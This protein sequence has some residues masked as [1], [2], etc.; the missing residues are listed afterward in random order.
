MTVFSNFWRS[1]LYFCQKNTVC[2]KSPPC[3]NLPQLTVAVALTLLFACQY[4]WQTLYHIWKN[5]NKEI[6]SKPSLQP[7]F[8][9]LYQCLYLRVGHK[10]TSSFIVAF[11]R[12]LQHL[13][14]S[15]PAP[16]PQ[17]GLSKIVWATSIK[18]CLH[19]PFF[20]QQQ[21]WRF[22][23]EFFFPNTCKVVV[24]AIL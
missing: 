20:S 1:I 12:Y 18:I 19:P 6:S 8:N 11:G 10:F 3:P 15:P 13:P 5:I 17:C 16:L 23:H 14:P 24:V 7:N 21:I 2:L 4:G 22:C 9:I